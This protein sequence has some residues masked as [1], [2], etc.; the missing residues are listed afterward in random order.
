MKRLVAG[1]CLLT[2]LAPAVPAQERIDLDMIGRIRQEGYKHSQVMDTASELMDRI[3]PR[4]TGSPQCKAANEWTRQKLAEWGLANAHLETWGPFGRGWS[5]QRST[6]RMLSPDQ[7][8]L[9]ALPKGWTPGT[10]GPVRA[11]VIHISVKEKSDFDKYKGQVAGKLVLYGDEPKMED[12]SKPDIERYDEKSLAEVTQYVPPG[13]PYRRY[14]REEYIKRMELRREADKF[15][16]TEKPL[17]ILAAGRGDLGTF[18]VQG[19]DWKVSKPMA[20]TPEVI[21]E[22]EHFGRMARLVDRGVDVE[23]ELEVATKFIDEN[24]MQWDTIAE[25]P[26][27]DKKDEVVML[28]AHLDSWYGGTGATDNGAGSVAVMEAMRILKAV[29]ARPRRTIRIGLW[30]GEEQG[31]YGSEAYVAQHFASRPPKTKEEEEL[32][33]YRQ[34]VKWP[35]T[36]KPEHA[37]LAAYFNLDNGSG[38]IRGIYCEDNAAVMPIFEAWLAPFHDM[39]ATVVTMNRTG[40]TDHESF[41]AVGLPGFQFVQD[42]LDYETKTHHT[43]M[44][45]YERL[46]KDDLMQASIILASFA[47]NAA[48]RD[49][50]LPR[51]PVPTEESERKEEPKADVKGPTVKKEGAPAAAPAPAP[52]PGANPK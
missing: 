45:L 22:P 11:K 38:K 10:N 9:I 17:A 16:E 44:D 41:D 20:T 40:G 50:M 29:G 19:G 52:T 14:N 2:L 47:Y 37:K 1:V 39:G 21:V 32:P 34:K 51:K 49:Q 4:L 30:T 8:E 43:N 13:T 15:F 18:G 46:S 31:L 36:L 23:V 26:G 3:G 35:L 48:M 7:A 5:Y 25:L 33:W 12:H 27:T 24:Q 6:L 42:A 28:G